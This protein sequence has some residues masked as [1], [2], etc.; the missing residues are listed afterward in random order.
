[1]HR[2]PDLAAPPSR[3]PAVRTG[4]PDRASRCGLPHG[5]RPPGA[6]SVRR[7]TPAWWL[8][9]RSLSSLA[10]RRS[11]AFLSC[12]AGPTAD[13][14]RVRDLGAGSSSAAAQRRSCCAGT[15]CRRSSTSGRPRTGRLYLDVP[16]CRLLVA[17]RHDSYRSLPHRP[18][19]CLPRFQSQPTKVKGRV[20][21]LPALDPWHR[22]WTRPG[23]QHD[24]KPVEFLE[25]L[26]LID[27]VVAPPVRTLC[28][29]H[30]RAAGAGGLGAESFVSFHQ[31]GQ[32]ALGGGG[33][34]NR[35]GVVTYIRDGQSPG[36]RPRKLG[37]GPPRAGYGG[38][39][40]S[41]ASC[42]AYPSR[43]GGRGS[44]PAPP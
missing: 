4:R 1:M 12:T 38:G 3:K 43:P 16:T 9:L 21:D 29:E 32:H 14:Q 19:L 34:W 17:A 18:T 7:S 2:W 27:G 36:R 26:D 24:V 11:L 28:G 10:A 37:D 15:A 8:A 35:A 30:A 42:G 13:V 22:V 6:N 33:A 20:E 44:S 40:C 23:V 39:P 5:V 41:Q 31:A 25:A